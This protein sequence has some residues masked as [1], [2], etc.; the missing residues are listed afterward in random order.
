M[1]KLYKL[2]LSWHDWHEPEPDDPIA[3]F[4]GWNTAFWFIVIFCFVL[5]AL[6]ERQK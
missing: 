3:D 6:G 4:S 2:I 1:F 5:F